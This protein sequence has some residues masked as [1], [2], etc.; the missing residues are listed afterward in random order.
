MRIQEYDLR[1]K[2][3][4][5]ASSFLA[6]TTGRNPA[7]VSESEIK[8]LSRPKDIIQVVK[9]QHAQSDG[10]CLLRHDFLYSKD[11]NNYPYWRPVLPT[12]L[13]VQVIKFVR[14]S[15]GH[16]GTEKCMAEIANTF[17]VRSSGR[18]VRK[19]ISHCDTCQ[20]VKHPNCSYAVEV[21][22]H[23]PTAPGELC[24]VDLYRCLQTGR[25]GVRY[26]LV[27]LDVFTKFVKLY[28]LRAV[29]TKT[30]LNKIT[31][32]YVVDVIRPKCILSDNGTQFASPL[33][34]TK[35]TELDIDVRF[36]P[37]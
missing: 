19:L 33:W 24:A 20:R 36:S 30:C 37:I 7:G 12:A 26:I 31:T 23:L 15:L 14:V 21:R 29:T 17:N 4:G 13:E 25:A 5:G 16:V 9:Q 18:K 6:D 1:T 10:N 22:S 35:L 34:R 32:C 27:V 2:H 11:S 28:P 8:G 3:I